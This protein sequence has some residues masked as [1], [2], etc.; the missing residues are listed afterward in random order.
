MAGSSPTPRKAKTPVPW[1]EEVHRA[2]LFLGLSGVF[3]WLSFSM[4]G[5]V[6]WISGFGLLFPDL[7]LGWIAVLM[8]IAAW[9]SLWIG[10]RELKREHP[11][12]HHPI[13]AW[14]AFL[15]T[16]ALV[17]A[18]MV[19][20]PIR[21]QDL[22]ST[23]AWILV[24]YVSALPFLAWTFVPTLALH[25]VIFGRVS[26]YLNPRGKHIADLGTMILFAVAASTTALILQF[27]AATSFVQT[28]SVGRGLLPAASCVGYVLIATGMS[29]WEL[30]EM[31]EE[32]KPEP[33]PEPKHARAPF[34][35]SVRA[36]TAVAVSVPGRGWAYAR[37]PR[38]AVTPDY[39]VSHR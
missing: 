12:D 9:P 16:L 10:L 23:T 35:R 15:L 29:L 22:S 32:P 11:D 13:L 27:P 39:V 1:P 6:V 3:Y 30:P 38:R 8:G 37:T 36:P 21:Y 14:R 33:K 24:L 31:K 25:G 17:L 26:N 34:A 7:I 18:G 19:F 2:A 4:E 20:L 5:S 28:W